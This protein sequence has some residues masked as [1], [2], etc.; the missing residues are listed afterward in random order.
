MAR[1][2]Q[3][4]SH[5]VMS[6]RHE[7]RDS[8]DD[9]PCPPWGTRALFER[10][11]D[12]TDLI[13]QVGLDP[14]CGRGHMVHAMR[15][16]FASVQAMDVFDYGYG[17]H[18]GS[19]LD[20][21]ETF[22]PPPH[23]IIMNPPFREAEKMI[24]RALKLATVG[25]ACLVRTVFIE[26]VHRYKEIY[27]VR[28]PATV[29]VFA[30]RLPMVRGRADQKATTATSYSWLVWDC[31]NRTHSSQPTEMLWIPPCRKMLEQPGDYFFR[32]EPEI[33]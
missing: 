8:L 11:L 21:E 12:K 24:S 32:L 25:V 3:N 31:V 1:T 2:T 18:V 13:G 16:Y 9:Y 5:A 28:P 26:G 33:A 23:W 4:R 10:V 17:F 19:F 15:P 29:A 14:C 6:R 27:R 30:E 22:D 20:R 7:P